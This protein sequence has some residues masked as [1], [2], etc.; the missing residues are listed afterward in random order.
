M[1]KFTEDGEAWVE[2]YERERLVE[3]AFENHR[4]WDV[5]RWKKG[6]QYFRNIQVATISSSLKLSRTTVSRQWDDKYY[7]YPIPQ[8]ELKKNPNLTQNQGW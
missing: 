4:V 7:F 2:R 1:P 3:L 8:T 6:P 5:R